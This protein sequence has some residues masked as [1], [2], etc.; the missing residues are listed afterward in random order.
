MKQSFG[1]KLPGTIPHWAA[2]VCDLPDLVV[3]LE[4]I[5]F[6]DVVDGE[7]ILFTPAMHHPGGS[8]NMVHGRNTQLSDRS[9]SIVVFAAAAARTTRI[10]FTTSVLLPAAHGFAVLARQASTL[11]AISR[12]RFTLGVGMGWNATEFEAQGIAPR[13]RDARAEDVIRACR[14]LWQPGLSTYHGRWIHFDEVISEPAPFTPGGPPV[15]WG[16]NALKGPTAARVAEFCQGWL[17]REAADYDEIAR[18]VDSVREECVKRGRDQ[19]TVSYRC[20]LTPTGWPVPPALDD[21]IDGAIASARR[22]AGAGITNFT[23]PINYYQL[24]TTALQHLLGALR[25]A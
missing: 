16:G 14:Q 23:V 3:E 12:G 10:R 2:S 18:S 17:S 24:D 1:A 13:E 22:F 15:W 5:G 7:H 19:E 4:R 8:G 11:D 6:D 9:D 21:L 20:S 25:S